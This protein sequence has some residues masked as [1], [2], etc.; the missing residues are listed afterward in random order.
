[1]IIASLKVSNLFSNALKLILQWRV[2]DLGHETA[3]DG[4]PLR[5]LPDGD[6][7]GSTVCA[8]RKEAR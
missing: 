4:S 6:D 7:H 5:A 2:S 8:L 3:L 1:M